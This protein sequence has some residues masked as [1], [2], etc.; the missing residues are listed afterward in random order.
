MENVSGQIISDANS[1]ELERI[2]NESSNR[3]LLELDPNFWKEFEEDATKYD[4]DKESEE[5]LMEIDGTIL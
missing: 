1:E 4:L 2:T 5:L 3:V